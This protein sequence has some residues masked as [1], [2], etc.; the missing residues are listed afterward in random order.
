MSKIYQLKIQLD[1]VSKPTVYRRVLVKATD[2]LLELHKIIQGAMGWHDCHL[3]QFMVGR[4][5]FGVIIPG[6]NWNDSKDERKYKLS[7]IFGD[8]EKAKIKYE[9]D[10]GDDW[11]HTITLEKIVAIT[12]TETY[13]QLIKGQGFCPPEDCG[14]SWGYEELKV[15]LANPESEEYQD[16]VD[17]LCLEDGSDFDPKEFDLEEMQDD[18]IRRYKDKNDYTNRF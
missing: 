18:M 3:H 4:Q 13:P 6:D 17:W 11:S 9:Y 1:G 16:M 12:P 15:T 2:T 5:S 8:T 7:Q 14:G 10:F